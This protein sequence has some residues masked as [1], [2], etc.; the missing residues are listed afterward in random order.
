MDEFEKPPT[1]PLF[2]FVL[3]DIVTLLNEMQVTRAL[4]YA[5]RSMVL[6]A[7]R[8]DSD[9]VLVA[10]I[11]KSISAPPN[12]LHQ[13]LNNL[14]RGG[15][16]NC[17]RGT[18]RGY[19]LARPPEQISLFDVFELI[20]GPLGLTACTVEGNWCPREAGCTLSQVWHGVQDDISRRLQGATLD[21][22][23]ASDL[24]ESDCPVR[25]E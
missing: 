13:V 4:E 15:L 23:A 2:R 9:P 17:H 16:L 24:S 7:A 12:F 10:D 22:L 11:A 1:M 14:S 18:K 21:K 5:N 20:E 6:L 19:Q 25:A 8:F 3:L